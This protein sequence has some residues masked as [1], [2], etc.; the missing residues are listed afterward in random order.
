MNKR[1]SRDPVMYWGKSV[2]GSRLDKGIFYRMVNDYVDNKLIKKNAEKL[3]EQFNN[4][5]NYVKHAIQTVLNGGG[6]REIMEM[7]NANRE[8]FIPYE[9]A[10]I[11]VKD[12]KQILNQIGGE[13]EDGDTSGIVESLVDRLV[14]DKA[15]IKK[16]IDNYNEFK[17]TKDKDKQEELKMNM[18]GIEKLPFI[19]PLGTFLPVAASGLNTIREIPVLRE[20]YDFTVLGMLLFN[21][22]I[23]DSLIL[24]LKLL[25]IPSAIVKFF[26]NKK[27]EEEIDEDYSFLQDEDDKS[28]RKFVIQLVGL[29]EEKP[30][31]HAMELQVLLFRGRKYLFDQKTNAVFAYANFKMGDLKEKQVKE[32]NEKNERTA[33][34]LTEKVFDGWRL[35]SKSNSSIEDDNFVFKNEKKKEEISLD[36][37]GERLDGIDEKINN[38]TEVETEVENKVLKG[39]DDDDGDDDDDEDEKINIENVFIPESGDFIP[40]GTYD[41]ILQAIEKLK[42][43]NKINISEQKKKPIQDK[44]LEKEKKIEKKLKKVLI[45][46]KKRHKNKYKKQASSLKSNINKLSKIHV[47]EQKQIK[48]QQKQN[49]KRKKNLQKIFRKFVKKDQLDEKKIRNKN[50]TKEELEKNRDDEG[51]TILINAIRNKKNKTNKTSNLINSLLEMKIDVSVEDNN[52]NNAIHWAISKGQV[53]ILKKMIDN[54]DGKFKDA[55][56]YAV[57]QGKTIIVQA[58]LNGKDEMKK[59]GNVQKILTAR[60]EDSSMTE[61]MKENFKKIANTLG[62]DEST[63]PEVP[64]GGSSDTKEPVQVPDDFDLNDKE[65]ATS[66]NVKHDGNNPPY[67]GQLTFYRDEDGYKVPIISWHPSYYF[68]LREQIE[69][70]D[71]AGNW[72]QIL[73]SN[74]ASPTYEIEHEGKILDPN[75]KQ[76]IELIK[77]IEKRD[78]LKQRIADREAKLNA[79]KENKEE[80]EQKQDPEITERIE[81]TIGEIEQ[82]KRQLEGLNDWNLEQK[83]KDEERSKKENEAATLI[84]RNIRKKMFNRGMKKQVEFKEKLKKVGYEGKKPTESKVVHIKVPNVLVDAVQNLNSN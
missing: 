61:K 45:S 33:L 6:E 20:I 39:G 27:T 31:D 32:T 63:K 78:W 76:D 35:I 81:K 34:G 69:N 15:N 16:R 4:L 3:Y 50:I 71:N 24:N 74:E 1:Y 14:N 80:T 67:L 22:F 73:D 60:L 30:F 62:L 55:F 21:N 82:L 64:I 68:G 26:S 10:S 59:D 7:R 65:N 41:N 75:N 13:D 49:E 9:K 40:A 18:R 42:E 11:V 51:R 70:P 46:E 72:G 43:K 66:R 58:L 48:R 83:K 29:E 17:S 56:Y 79:D 52:N 57:D 2:G 8:K 37:L 47:N 53:E 77:L 23:L 12:I 28:F 5:Q 19:P 44:I 84:Q 36:D 38:D 54:D 25:K